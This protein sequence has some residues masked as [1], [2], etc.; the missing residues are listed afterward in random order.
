MASWEDLVLFLAWRELRSRTVAL[1]LGE[2][3]IPCFVVFFVSFKKVRIANLLFVVYY[4]IY[5][6]YLLD[7][8]IYQLTYLSQ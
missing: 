8:Y 4:I 1:G 6:F 5:Y 7:L 2:G 3:E